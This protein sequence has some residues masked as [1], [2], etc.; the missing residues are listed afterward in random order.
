MSTH[1]NYQ[2]VDLHLTKA[3]AMYYRVSFHDRD[4]VGLV[5]SDSVTSKTVF[6]LYDS[7]GKKIDHRTTDLLNETEIVHSFCEWAFPLLL[8]YPA[9]IKRLTENG[10]KIK[11]YRSIFDDWQKSLDI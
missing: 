10:Y 5:K 4:T 8:R 11:K 3:G 9:E 6:F 2:G 1:F 7:T